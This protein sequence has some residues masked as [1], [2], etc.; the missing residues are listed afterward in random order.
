MKRLLF[1]YI[2]GFIVISISNCTKLSIATLVGSYTGSMISSSCPDNLGGDLVGLEMRIVITEY[3][4]E[5][6]EVQL[7]NGSPKRAKLKENDIYYGFDYVEQ[8]YTG[9]DGAEITLSG[10]GSYS[11]E[12][13][14]INIS[15]EKNGNKCTSVIK[16]EKD[17]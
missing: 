12:G 14:T 13:L 4:D 17:E 6:I 9:S 8:I 7:N 3:S 15:Y 1:F 16:A 2:M 5:F 10:N 11:S